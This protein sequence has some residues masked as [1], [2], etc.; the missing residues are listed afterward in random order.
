[1]LRV[2]MENSAKTAIA[3]YKTAGAY[4]TGMGVVINPATGV[5]S[6]PAAAT[7]EDIYFLSK[8]KVPMGIETART[9]FSDWE[10]QFNTFV[11]GEKCRLEHFDFTDIFE[12]DQYDSTITET[13]IGKRVLVG[14][15]GKIA[16]AD[17]DQSSKYVFEGFYKEG[18]HT[19]VRVRV[20]DTATT[21]S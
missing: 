5:A 3:T 8:D 10:E 21:N 2:L 20:T 15:D 18:A 1:M 17:F 13:D 14:A 6:L 16:L 7:G 9:D 11:V 19:L 4:K 12:T